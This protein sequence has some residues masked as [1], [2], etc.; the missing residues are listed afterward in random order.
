[1]PNSFRAISLLAAAALLIGAA[2][3][4]AAPSSGAAP[5]ALSVTLFYE[6]RLLVKVV[7]IR[8]DQVVEPN[9]FRLGARLHTAALGAVLKSATF[10]AQAEGPMLAGGAVPSAFISDDG[11][12]HRVVRYHNVSPRSPADPLTQLLRA[13]LSPGG[14]SP[15]LGA[16]RVEDGL[17]TYDLILTPAGPGALTAEQKGLDLSAPVRCW[18]GFRPLS[19]VKPGASLRNPF[20]TGELSATFARPAAA[21]LWVMSDIA[22]GTVLGEGHIALTGLKLQGA[23]PLASIASTAHQARPIRP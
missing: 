13:A 22:I 2:S 23:R 12:R 15:C 7:D 11:K 18:L 16:L 6:G 17:Q 14:V 4:E 8:A 20:M 21:D 3:A 9:G 1:M 5:Q 19:G 10:L